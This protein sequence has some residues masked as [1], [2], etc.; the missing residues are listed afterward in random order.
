MAGSRVPFNVRQRL[1]LKH[2]DCFNS[3][4]LSGNKT[5]AVTE[6]Q[7]QRLNPGASNRDVTLPAVA[8]NL[9]N[10]Y[11]IMHTGTSAV[12]L[13]VKNAGGTTIATVGRGEWVQVACDGA[14]WVVVAGSESTDDV[15]LATIAVGN[16]TGGATG[17]T[18]ALT[19][20][21]ANGAALTSAKQVAIF[22]SD[23]Q[24][25]PFPNPTAIN[26]VTFGTATV[27]SI[28]A[29]GNGWA[30]VETS[31]AGA[32][33]CTCSNSDDE[34][35]YFQVANASGSDAAKACIVK[36]SNCDGATWS[37]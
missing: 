13:V 14:S 25:A 15:V 7:F 28:V 6:A 32:F 27:G 30:L 3:E 36:Y 18:C 5:I 4:T 12:N 34:T 19:L 31:A 23:T 1:Q 16:A 11:C 10:W 29:S 8:T 21:R 20:T 37:A 24:Y 22:G 33:A 9:G 2:D 17:A 35:L 26:S